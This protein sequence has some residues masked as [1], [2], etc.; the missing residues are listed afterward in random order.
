MKKTLLQQMTVKMGSKPV[1]FKTKF[2][3]AVDLLTRISHV[4][5]DSPILVVTDSWF[6]NAS[7]L[8]PLRLTIGKRV[9]ILSRLRGNA[10]LYA[11]LAP[12]CSLEDRGRI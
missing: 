11:P 7:L 6:S 1:K 4:F 5:V 12:C 9:Q 2:E 3:Q 8:K 10:V